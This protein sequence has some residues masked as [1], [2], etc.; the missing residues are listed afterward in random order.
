VIVVLIGVTVPERLQQRQ[1]SIAAAA[2]VPGYTLERAFFQ[3]RLRYGRIPDDLG[4]L[5]V[6]PDADGSIAAAL[7]M[8]DSASA[9]TA[10][11]PSADVA[12]LPTQKPR[13]LR[14]AV[15]RNAS[16]S[17][18]P[19]DT[20]ADGLSFTNYELRLPGPDKLMGTDDDLVLRDGVI[21]KA[22]DV[23]RHTSTSTAAG[24]SKH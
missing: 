11:K 15:I 6:L 22:S 18:G 23:P 12:A 13:P 19:D 2:L 3:Y 7:S 9:S 8:Y 17:S 4:D 24:R 5:R 14:G 10:Y 21:T 20:L 1:L 16:V